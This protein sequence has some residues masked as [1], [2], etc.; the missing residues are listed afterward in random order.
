[1]GKPLI[2]A[3]V[4]LVALGLLLSANPALFHWFGRLPGD[5]HIKGEH[6]ELFIPVT[7]MLILSVA[8]TILFNLFFRR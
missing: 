7:S 5:I 1:M 3:G 4:V 6:G 2:W 8:A